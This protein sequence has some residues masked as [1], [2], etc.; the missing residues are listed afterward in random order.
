[1]LPITASVLLY[2]VLKGLRWHYYLRVVDVEVTLRR[3]LAAYLAGQWFTFTPAGELMR[4]YLL[5][6]GTEFSRVAATV[7]VQVVTDF[8][9]LA[10]LATLM[11]PFYPALASVV[12]PVTTPLLLTAAM[13]ATPPLR[14]YAATWGLVR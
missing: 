5:G 11:V 9:S 14:R 12:L 13:V 2:Y 4:A 3:S 7:V 8:V 6:A 10:L 1:M